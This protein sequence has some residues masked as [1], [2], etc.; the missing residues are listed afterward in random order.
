MCKNEIHGLSS[1]AFEF[2]FADCS[3]SDCRFGRDPDGTIS[4]VMIIRSL[5][6]KSNDEL[7][8]CTALNLSAQRV[9]EALEFK[10]LFS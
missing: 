6:P 1:A 4:F 2:A 5:S 7:D 3:L 8:I 10:L 9:D